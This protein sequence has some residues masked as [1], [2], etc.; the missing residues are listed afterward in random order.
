M[1]DA[2]WFMAGA[3]AVVLVLLIAAAVSSAWNAAVTR[4]AA[5]YRHA[6]RCREHS[7]APGEWGIPARCDR[8]RGH[9]GRHTAGETTWEDE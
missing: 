4:R 9:K 8:M 7:P 2:A 3:A 5:E 6:M 1:T